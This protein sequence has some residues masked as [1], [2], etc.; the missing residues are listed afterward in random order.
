MQSI[1][2]SQLGVCRLSHAK[3]TGRAFG[4]D[5]VTCISSTLTSFTSKPCETLR[6]LPGRWARGSLSPQ[7]RRLPPSLRWRESRASEPPIASSPVASQSLMVR[8][9]VT[10]YVKSQ[11]WKSEAAAST[12]LIALRIPNVS[13]LS[14]PPPSNPLACGCFSRVIL[15]PKA[16]GPDATCNEPD[17]EVQAKT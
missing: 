5:V 11:A 12:S 6:G 1:R 17:V 9:H 4:L 15:R 3:A 10:K 2:R 13:L 14:N 7:A 8:R 16:P